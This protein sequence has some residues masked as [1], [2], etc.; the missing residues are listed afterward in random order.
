MSV[1]FALVFLCLLSASASRAADM[2]SALVE[3]N[4]LPFFYGREYFVLRSGRAQM[5]VQADKADLGPAFTFLLFDVE[6]A[7]QSVRKEGAFNFDQTNGFASSAL[8]V[9]LGGFPFAALGHR[10]ETKWVNTGG[11]PAVE[12][13]WWAGGVRVTER[14]TALVDV[15]VFRRS[16][17]LEGAHLIG[18]ETVKLRL[19]LPPGERQRAGSLLFWHGNG[20]RLALAVVGSTPAQVQVGKGALEIGPL[21]I[22][23]LWSH[24]PRI[25]NE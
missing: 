7:S 25:P 2:N 3:L 11:I 24:R 21:A 23:R 12:A 4:K 14:L 1:R 5:L 22:T 8:E 10:T 20:A 18:Q 17:Q 6:N 16:I 13:V 9:D 19:S 15:S